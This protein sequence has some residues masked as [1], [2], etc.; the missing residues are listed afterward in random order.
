L[1]GLCRRARLWLLRRIRP[2]FGFGG[3]LV[4]QLDLLAEGGF[5]FIYLA[6]D[7]NGQQYALK[8]QICQSKESVERCVQEVK[9]LEQ[10]AGVRGVVKLWAHIQIPVQGGCEIYAL[11]DLVKG[12]NLL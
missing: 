2:R 4:S 6:V 10:C 1:L 8:K 3:R 12:G 9:L 5:S 7:Q 11:L